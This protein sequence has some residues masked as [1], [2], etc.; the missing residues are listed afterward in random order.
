MRLVNFFVAY[1]R[2]CNVGVSLL[3]DKSFANIFNEK[4]TTKKIKFELEL[5]K[6]LN[7]L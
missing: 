5:L 2:K 1:L 7:H 6:L 4:L 3:K